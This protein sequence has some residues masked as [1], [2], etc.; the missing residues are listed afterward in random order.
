MAIGTKPSLLKRQLLLESAFIGLI[1]CCFGLLVGGLAAYALQVWGFDIRKIVD[2]SM[3]ISGF[4]V[5]PIM[6]ARLTPSLIIWLGGIVMGATLL[7][8]LIP[9]RRVKK[10][11]IAETLR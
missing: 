9:M 10:I 3:N 11:D 7:L 6:H 1:G 4:A 2:E 5:S 8:S